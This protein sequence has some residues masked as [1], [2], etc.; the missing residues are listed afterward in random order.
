[1]E[2]ERGWGRE[3]NRDKPLS[4]RVGSVLFNVPSVSPR[5][6]C[7][8]LSS[9]FVSQFGLLVIIPPQCQLSVWV[10]DL[11]NQKKKVGSVLGLG[12]KSW[13]YQTQPPCGKQHPQHPS[14]VLPSWR[15]H[16]PRSL[17]LAARCDLSALPGSMT[18]SV[19]GFFAAAC[20]GRF[21]TPPRPPS[22]KAGS[23]PLFRGSVDP[24]LARFSCISL[25]NRDFPKARRREH[26]FAL[27]VQRQPS[28]ASTTTTAERILGRRCGLG[29]STADGHA[30]TA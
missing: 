22:L 20:Q 26:L 14:S 2:E 18:A 9:S 27:S 29:G 24:W 10:R 11:L 6:D 15:Q 17:I 3:G 7:F 23:R 21:T 13:A 25:M 8:Q 12:E 4:M 5:T 16:H 1:M 30:D 19:Q 28:A